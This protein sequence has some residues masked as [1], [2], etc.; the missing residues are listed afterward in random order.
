[1]PRSSPHRHALTIRGRCGDYLVPL[2]AI[3][4]RRCL[5]DGMLDE[6]RVV[7]GDGKTT[8]RLL[9]RLFL[10]ALDDSLHHADE[11]PIHALARALMR[12][13]TDSVPACPKRH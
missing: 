3:R 11:S 5:A 2:D 10:V 1:M 12:R 9:W 6:Q 8:K 7:L 4:L 13:H